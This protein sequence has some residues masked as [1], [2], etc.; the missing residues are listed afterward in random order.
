MNLKNQKGITLMAEVITVVIFM[1]IIATITY[2]STSS[3]QIRALNDM[4]AD[5][6]NI[7]EKAAN[8]YLKYGEAPVTTENVTVTADKLNPN[9]AEGQ[10]YKV[11]FGKLIN[12]ALN[13]EQKDESYYYMNTK[14][15]TVYYNPGVIINKLNTDPSQETHYTLPSNYSNV[16]LITVS[17]YQ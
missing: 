7:Q 16:N 10:Y 12:V 8:Y 5:I 15:L 4:Y 6:I 2:S 11:D 17:Q 14:T 1:I 9:D 13:N 3:M